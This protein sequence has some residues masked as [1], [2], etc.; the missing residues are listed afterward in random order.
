MAERRGYSAGVPRFVASAR[1]L[2]LL[3]TLLEFNLTDYA[4]KIILFVKLTVEPPL[5]LTADVRTCESVGEG[6]A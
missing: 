5:D 4:L 2:C 6:E 1:A 3:R